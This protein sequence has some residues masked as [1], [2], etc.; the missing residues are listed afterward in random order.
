VPQ[1]INLYDA[2]V[3]R[4]DDEVNQIVEH[5]AALGLAERTLIVIY[6]DHGCDFF[7]NNTWGQGNT[8]E[9]SD[10]GARIPLII[11]DPRQAE[12]RQVDAVVRSVDLAPTLCTLLGLPPLP[13]ADGVSLH[14]LMEGRAEVPELPAFQETGVWLGRIPGQHPEHLRY[15]W[16]PDLL[17]VR[18][19]RTGTLSLKDEYS[20]LL[21]EARDRMIRKG[22]WKLVYLPLGKGAEYRLYDVEQDPQCR[23]DLAARHPGML[24]SL[25][26]ELIAWML[27][28]PG[29]RWQDE[30]LVPGR[31]V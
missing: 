13:G 10:P 18:D 25:K 23:F 17:E 16:L 24:D 19:R 30:H 14:A 27:Q 31:P 11:V 3:R 26:A 9:G 7:E 12:T 4:F 5:L 29:R 2:C 15:P 28:E 21:I 22:R 1:I 20:D 8:V 6:S